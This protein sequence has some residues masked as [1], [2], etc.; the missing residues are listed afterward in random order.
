MTMENFNEE[1]A[2]RYRIYSVYRE[3]EG[4][5]LAKPPNID[6]KNPKLF[7]GTHEDQDKRPAHC[8]DTGRSKYLGLHKAPMKRK[9]L[10]IFNF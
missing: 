9:F 3:S 8:M 4:G 1:G 5:R 6:K 7:L 10:K 2:N